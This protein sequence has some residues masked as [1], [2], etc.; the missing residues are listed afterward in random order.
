MN[1]KEAAQHLEV[2]RTLMER[3]AVYRL[4]LAPPMVL[5]GN[6]GTLGALLALRLHVESG[7]RFALFWM[8][9]CLLAILGA[10]FLTRRQAMG[11]GEPLWSMPARRVV[12]AALPAL[13][14]GG[15]SGLIA[16]LSGAG[17]LRG[18]SLWLGFY[19]CAL[20][21]AGFFTVR[22]MRL[23]GLM[24]IALALLGLLIDAEMIPITLKSPGNF[25]MGLGFGISHLAYAAYLKWTEPKAGLP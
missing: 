7:P 2:I 3:S 5:A 14:L 17:S 9:V 10:L 15:A 24:L 25:M 4:A 8:S 16:H 20:H 6:L 18:A 21:A 11:A 12:F 1:S 22:G 19:G 13:I 23:M